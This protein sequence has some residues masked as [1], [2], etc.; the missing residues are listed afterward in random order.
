MRFMESITYRTLVKSTFIGT[1]TILS[2]PV[3]AASVNPEAESSTYEQSSKDTNYGESLPEEDDSWVDDTNDYLSDMV[4]GVGEYID[5]GLAKD[6]DEPPLVNK[7][8]IRLRTSAEYSHRG[9]LD[10]NNRLSVRIDLPHTEHD[11]KLILE[12]D[13]DDYDDLESKARGTPASSTDNTGAFGG[14]RL[15]DEQ[16]SHWKTSFDIGVKIRWPPDPFTRA[17][18]RRV[19][20]ISDD[21]TTQFSQEFFYFYSKGLGSL[22]S[23]NFYLDVDEPAGQIFKIGTSAQYLYDDDEW[24]VLHQAQYFDRIN[25]KNLMEYSAG[26]S[27]YPYD[28]DEVSN[29]WLSASWIRKLYKNW[30]FL[31][32]RPQLELPREYDYKMNPGIYVQFEAFFSKNRKADRLNRYIPEPTTKPD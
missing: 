31:T 21:W 18:V 30:L 32:V 9:Y 8:Y 22:T 28:R 27:L 13:P 15:Q 4:L 2:F 24:E 1:C 26:I 12:T 7:S 17:E 20:K 3:F 25:D 6:E 16:I 5:H 10:T 23:L 29:M 14:I 11:W 19:G